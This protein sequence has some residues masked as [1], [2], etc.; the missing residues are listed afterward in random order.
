MHRHASSSATDRYRKECG[1]GEGGRGCEKREEGV[2]EGEMRR[3]GGMKREGRMRGE[4]GGMQGESGVEYGSE[5]E[6]WCESS[7]CRRGRER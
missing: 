2:E 6:E 4:G 1:G 7:L 3:D 5:R